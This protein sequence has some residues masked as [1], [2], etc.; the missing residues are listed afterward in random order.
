MKILITG[1]AGYIGTPLVDLLCINPD[2]K[3]IIVYDNLSRSNYNLFIGAK[4]EGHEK[5]TF[6]RGELLDSRKLK[7]T[8]KG[9]DVVYHL[10]ARVTT[11]FANSDAH[12]F[13]Q[14]NHWGTAELAYLLEESS[15][16]KLI[17]IFF[18]LY[19]SL[20]LDISFLFTPFTSTLSSI[21]FGLNFDTSILSGLNTLNPFIPPKY[22]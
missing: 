6:I 1:G 16:K 15:V 18:S 22:I 20:V 11:P 7:Q 8:L 13:D 14:I 19:L 4:K 21:T 10:A 12:L 5:I 17:F 3:K 9:V 2:V